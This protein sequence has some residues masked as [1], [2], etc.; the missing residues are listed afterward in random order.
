MTPTI[1][2][3]F[4]PPAPSRRSAPGIRSLDLDLAAELMVQA[5]NACA[6][7]WR[8]DVL[9]DAIAQ[10]RRRHRELGDRDIEALVA[11][12]RA[13]MDP[14]NFGRRTMSE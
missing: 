14:G 9:G 11:A 10:L 8:D 6:A 12:V 5:L 7:D 1:A 3:T 13:R 4:K 2:N